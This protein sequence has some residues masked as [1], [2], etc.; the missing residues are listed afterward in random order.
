MRAK[1]QKRRELALIFRGSAYALV[2]FGTAMTKT[3][4]TAIL[5]PRVSFGDPILNVL[6]PSHHVMEE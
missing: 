4:V 1:D 5:V 6:A 3:H 2:L